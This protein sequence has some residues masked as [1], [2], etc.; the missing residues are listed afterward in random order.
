MTEYPSERFQA[1]LAELARR[2]GP[3]VLAELGAA[4]DEYGFWC[5]A[6]NEGQECC[7]E[8]LTTPPEMATSQSQEPTKETPD[9][10]P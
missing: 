4:H 10:Q 7:L 9:D 8:W 3:E 6:R 5:V 2:I 1:Q